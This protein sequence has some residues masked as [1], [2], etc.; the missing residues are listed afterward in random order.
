ME[1]RQTDRHPAEVLKRC[2]VDLTHSTG[3]ASSMTM[4]WD[5]SQVFTRRT[6]ILFMSL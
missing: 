5:V 6:S 4:H 1:D 2:I 3:A